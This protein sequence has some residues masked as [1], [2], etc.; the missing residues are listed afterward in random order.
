MSVQTE[1]TMTTTEVHDEPKTADTGPPTHRFS[2]DDMK[3]VDM[4]ILVKPLPP[5]TATKGGL[6]IPE[7]HQAEKNI[8]QVVKAGPNA[9]F[10]VGQYI[11]YAKVTGED[12][13]LDDEEYLTMDCNEKYDIYGFWEPEAVES[14][15]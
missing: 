7:T 11:V 8:G 5:D 10:K 15:A 2:V 14:T 4:T 13:L 1:E 3:L 9:R 12:I 6:V